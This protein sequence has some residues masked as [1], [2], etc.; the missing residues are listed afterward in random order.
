MHVITGMP[1][2]LSTLLC[3]ILAQNESLFVSSTSVLSGLCAQTVRLLSASPE[4]RGEL[5]RDRDGTNARQI[6]VL[7]AMCG[8]W[9]ADAFRAGKTVFDKGRGWA[10]HPLMFQAMYPAGKALV[11][12]RDPRNVYASIEKQHRATAAWDEAQGPQQKTLFQR[13]SAMFASQGMIGVC[14]DAVVD[15]IQRKLPV[16]FVQAEDLAAYPAREM[17]KIYKYL[18]IEP[19][20]HDFKD[21]KNQATEVDAMWAHKYPH[22]AAGEVKPLNLNEWQQFMT[23]D[24]ASMIMKRCAVYNRFF[25][26][27]E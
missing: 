18:E 8:A 16:H 9:Y 27:R 6:R 13:A 3:N 24:I 7:Q 20:A 11:L 15:L 10:S 1:R 12:V 4:V 17:E 14:V 19:F 26:Y 22:Q 5:V 2:S 25:G 23:P 21:V